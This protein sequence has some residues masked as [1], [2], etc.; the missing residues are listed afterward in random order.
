MNRKA[1]AY[2]MGVLTVSLT[3]I[4]ALCTYILLQEDFVGGEPPKIGQKQEAIYKAYLKGE[5]TELYAE[6][7]LIRAEQ[8]AKTVISSQPYAER[9]ASY[10]LEII[11]RAP[12]EVQMPP[13]KSSVSGNIITLETI[14]SAAYVVGRPTGSGAPGTVTQPGPL[15]TGDGGF[16]TVWPVPGPKRLTSAFGKRDL[17]DTAASATHAGLDIGI[18]EPA[19]HN[20][21]ADRAK[22]GT[23]VYAVQDGY[24]YPASYKTKSGATRWTVQLETASGWHCEYMHVAQETYTKKPVRAGEQI[25]RIGYDGFTRHL[26]LRCYHPTFPPAI[27]RT[28]PQFADSIG[29]SQDQP[30]ET[31]LVTLNRELSTDRSATKA[32]LDTWCLFDP[33]LRRQVNPKAGVF[34]E[35]PGETIGEKAE[36]TCQ[37]YREIDKLARLLGIDTTPISQ[38]ELAAATGAVVT[39]TPIVTGNAARTRDAVAEDI[40][41]RIIRNECSRLPSPSDPPMWCYSNHPGDPPT[42]YGVTIDTLRANRNT[43][44]SIPDV[45]NL[46]YAEARTILRTKFLEE[47]RIIELPPELM[48]NVFDA[49]VMSGPGRS[50]RWLGEVLR[51]MGFDAPVQTSMSNELIAAAELAV[52][53]NGG[54][55]VNDAYVDRRRAFY[56]EIANDGLDGDGNPASPDPH[57]QFLEGWINR[58][59]T[60]REGSDGSTF[61]KALQEDLRQNAGQLEYTFTSVITYEVD[62]SVDAATQTYLAALSACQET[63]AV[64]QD[65]AHASRPAGS[66]PLRLCTDYKARLLLATEACAEQL[67]TGCSCQIPLPPTHEVQDL[68]ISFADARLDGD[69]ATL[70]WLGLGENHERYQMFYGDQEIS[71]V[72][73]NNQTP[74]TVNILGANLPA[75]NFSIQKRDTGDTH[76]EVVFDT[77]NACDTGTRL[78]WCSGSPDGPVGEQ[79]VYL[80]HP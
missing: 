51:D 57:A 76:I 36:Y 72:L 2:F 20:T 21:P 40:L 7:A 5:S 31:A 45:Q 73:W 33:E 68:M 55:A 75:Q 14:G 58:V 32:Y 49:G 12:P 17:D 6:A 47:P 23:P 64:C 34:D 1:M 27:A 48:V 13:Y 8:V 11:A 16:F 52:R 74:D 78:Q 63:D 28:I 30:K 4:L 22:D 38:E 18:N 54:A 10:A 53:T 59:E 70:D 24:A 61:R 37:T 9:V 67:A 25:G 15:P 50:I 69:V 66:E 19:G 46:P 44:V 80:S 60:F 39:E 29:G 35:R 71:A 43:P 77:T 3:I 62:D 41:D 65:N 26:D 56:E 42:R 79:T